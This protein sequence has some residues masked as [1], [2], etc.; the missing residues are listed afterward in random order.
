MNLKEMLRRRWHDLYYKLTGARGES[1]ALTCK[2]ASEAIDLDEI[3]KKRFARLRLM[4]HQSVCLS[5]QNYYAAT[6]ALKIA[7][8][9]LVQK[10]DQ[11]SSVE[12]INKELV[13][14]YVK[15]EAS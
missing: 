7:V 5:C 1:F 14:K 3:P 11:T 10:S 8:R 4:L 13:K 6:Q 15:D 12:R 9:K 2:E